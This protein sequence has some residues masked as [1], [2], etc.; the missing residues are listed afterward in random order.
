MT[1]YA[2]IAA[3][4]VA[5]ISCVSIAAATTNSAASMG[6][7][8]WARPARGQ[9]VTTVPELSALTLSTPRGAPGT[10]T[11]ESAPRARLARGN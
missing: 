1:R 2:I 6:L 9:S 7:E 8:T 4:A 5:A 11:L 10:L 3:A